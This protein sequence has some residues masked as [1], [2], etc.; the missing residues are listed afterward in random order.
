MPAH[1]LWRSSGQSPQLYGAYG[2]PLPAQH[3]PEHY[4]PGQT[5]AMHQ[6]PYTANPNVPYSASAGPY[7][8]GVPYAPSTHAPQPMHPYDDPNRDINRKRPAAEPHTPTLP[9][10]KPELTATYPIT[11]A[12]PGEYMYPDPAGMATS[13]TVSP[14]SS[15]SPHPTQQPVMPQPGQQSY[16]GA[17]LGAPV[18][19]GRSPPESS[20]PFVYDRARSS[21]SPHSHATLSSAAPGIG[22]AYQP[23]TPDDAMSRA[24]GRTPDSAARQQQQLG[25]RSSIPIRDIVSE[26][27]G[28]G[29]RSAADSNMLKALNRRPM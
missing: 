5:Q 2:Q 20:S 6:P 11:Q 13:S 17:H 12:R 3:P 28:S 16:Y 7:Q 21:T 10:P 1:T 26:Q 19:G 8:P 23:P 25:A 14:E 27:A 22:G 9:P 4:G 18:P 29:G 15:S 24:N